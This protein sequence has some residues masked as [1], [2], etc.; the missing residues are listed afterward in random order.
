[1]QQTN[2]VLFRVVGTKRIGTDQFRQPVRHVGIRAAHGPHFMQY[3]RNA[4]TRDL[5][6]GFRPGQSASNDVNVP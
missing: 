1:M 2:G 3:H 5:P 4:A 6:R